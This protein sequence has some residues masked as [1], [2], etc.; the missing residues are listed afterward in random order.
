M[1]GQDCHLLQSR[2]E[3]VLSLFS[4]FFLSLNAGFLN[5]HHHYYGWPIYLHRRKEGWLHIP[6]NYILYPWRTRIRV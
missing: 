5:D 6:H 4:Y 2:V 1:C 3:L